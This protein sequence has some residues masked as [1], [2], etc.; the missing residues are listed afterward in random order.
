M[1][2]FG[3]VLGMIGLLALDSQ[4]FAS[5]EAQAP[6]APATAAP[7]APPPYSLPWQLRPTAVGNVVRSDTAIAFYEDAAGNG[8]STVASMLLGT[9][10][11]TPELAP[12]VRLALVQNSPPTGESGVALVNP[13]FGATYSLKLDDSLRVALFLGLTL[14]VGMGG[15]DSPDAATKAARGS[16]V[17]ARSAMDNAMFSV[18]D[19]TVFPGVG[20]SYVKSG[21]TVQAEVTVLQL[22]R[23][24]GEKDQADS[25][26]TNSTMGLHVGYFVTPMLSLGGEI[27]YQRW[28][29]TPTFVEKNSAMRDTVTFAVGPRLHFKIGKT[30]WCRPGI[31]Y[32]RGLDDPMSAQKYNIVQVDVPVSF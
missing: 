32:A 5:G 16:G 3:F 10:K 2:A 11:V 29:T 17:L 26:K 7:K 23:V 28:L 13:A 9:Y 15:G 20:V 1:K 6:D 12:F 30:S 24:R 21:L 27:R 18:N 22:T 4:A 25:S 31:A 14:P 19:F 8:G